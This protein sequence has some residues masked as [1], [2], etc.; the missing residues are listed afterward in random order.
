MRTVLMLAVIGTVMG[1]ALGIPFANLVLGFTGNRF[2]G[3]T[4][5]W[6][7]PA[8]A[9]IIS[10]IVGVGATLLAALPALRRAARSSVLGG[11]QTASMK[12]TSGWL[13]RG[14]R[15]VHVPRTT[16]IGLRNVARRRTRTYATCSKS[17]WPLASRSDSWRWV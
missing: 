10:I 1:I 15:R 11:L 3:I 9:L 12:G 5:S 14:L 4:P 16:P 6:G 7:V 17:P 8:N 13:D 2:F